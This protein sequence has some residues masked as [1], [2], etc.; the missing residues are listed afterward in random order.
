MIA[1]VE[2]DQ[3]EGLAHVEGQ[4]PD[5]VHYY[6]EVGHGEDLHSGQEIDL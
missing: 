4:D 5:Q 3:K 1:V 2:A 6:H